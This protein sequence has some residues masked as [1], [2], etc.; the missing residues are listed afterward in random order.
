LVGGID[1]EF[2]S[3]EA[4][5]LGLGENCAKEG[6]AQSPASVRLKQT[7]AEHTGMAK[8]LDGLRTP[9]VAAAAPSPSTKM[10]VARS[11]RSGCLVNSERPVET[12][13]D[14]VVVPS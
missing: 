2:D 6:A 3:I 7:H 10:A 11:I 9:E 13:K 8:A 14:P 4:L 5:Q 1:L 12:P